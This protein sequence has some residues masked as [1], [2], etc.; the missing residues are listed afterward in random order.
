[1]YAKYQVCQP[2]SWASGWSEKLHASLPA[3]STIGFESD[4]ANTATTEAPAVRPAVPAALGRTPQS[5][6]LSL[7]QGHGNAAVARFLSEGQ[8][9]PRVHSDRFDEPVFHEILTG[10][11]TLRQGQRGP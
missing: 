8:H 11:K 1:M 10:R 4:H 5:V 2:H 6:M 3:H 9:K 7:Q